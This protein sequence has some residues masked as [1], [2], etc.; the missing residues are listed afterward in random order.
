MADHRS[1]EEIEREIE[2]DRQKLASTIDTLQDRFSIDGVASQ[3]TEHLRANGGEIARNIS[4]T[5]KQNP[6]AV[7]L[8]GAGLAWLAF[9]NGAR[10]MAHRVANRRNLEYFLWFCVW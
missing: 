3:V 5:I 6:V 2:H 4:G 8:V 7:A 10:D 9:G 1:P